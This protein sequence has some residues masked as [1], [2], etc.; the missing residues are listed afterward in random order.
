MR[1]EVW[2]WHTHCCVRSIVREKLLLCAKNLSSELLYPWDLKCKRNALNK[3]WGVCGN[4]ILVN[5]WWDQNKKKRKVVDD[6]PSFQAPSMS[7]SLLAKPF[8][9]RVIVNLELRYLLMREKK[10]LFL[11]F[12]LSITSE[13]LW[14]KMYQ[15]HINNAKPV[16]SS[17]NE[18]P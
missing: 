16:S 15:E 3:A 12:L 10:I 4:K 7:C 11:I 14:Y 6:L 18:L 1:K 5:S 8:S 9:K 13:E 2:T 17:W